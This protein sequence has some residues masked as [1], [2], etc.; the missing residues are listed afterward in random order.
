GTVDERARTSTAHRLV[1]AFIPGARDREHGRK[2]RFKRRLHS[3]GQ[4]SRVV[5]DPSTTG[6]ALKRAD[7]D[8]TLVCH[9]CSASVAARRAALRLDLANALAGP[10]RGAGAV[11][12][13]CSAPATAS[14]PAIAKQSFPQRSCEHPEH[15]YHSGRG[16]GPASFRGNTWR[17]VS[18][19]SV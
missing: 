8:R 11:A 9:E 2:A 5:D 10:I 12:P 15:G 14:A 7:R 19:R 13:P 18:V 6:T 1:V 16:E 4:G 3:P 17:N